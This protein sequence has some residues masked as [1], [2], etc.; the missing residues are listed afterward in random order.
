MTSLAANEIPYHRYPVNLL[1]GSLGFDLKRGTMAVIHVGEGDH[2][3]C[4]L[5]RLL[6]AH[7][8]CVPNRKGSRGGQ[9]YTRASVIAFLVP[10]SACG[11]IVF[12]AMSFGRHM[13]DRGHA[14][15][16]QKEWKGLEREK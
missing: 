7:T 1:L 10:L 9:R 13:T 5:Q 2:T 14:F 15:R 11:R 4:N 16:I 8:R 12:A 3:L 6:L